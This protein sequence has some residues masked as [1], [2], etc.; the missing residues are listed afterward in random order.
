MRESLIQLLKKWCTDKEGKAS[1]F[2]AETNFE[3]TTGSSK[4][5]LYAQWGDTNGGD[6]KD[7]GVF[8]YVISFIAI[9]PIAG[10]IYYVSKKKNLFKQI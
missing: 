7:T 8:S 1:C 3:N 10:T 2:D 5:T 6:N 4:V 9:G